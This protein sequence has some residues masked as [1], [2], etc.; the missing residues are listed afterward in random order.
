MTTLWRKSSYSGSG[1]ASDCVEL[2]SLDGSVGIRDS[3]NPQITHI[4]VGREGLARL[5]DQI[6]DG[7]LDPH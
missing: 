5:L 3:K 2:A 1:N 4:T 7:S 6:K